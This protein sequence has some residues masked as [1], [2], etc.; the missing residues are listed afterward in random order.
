M[1]NSDL[2]GIPTGFFDLD[3]R[4]D[5]L[6]KGKLVLITGEDEKKKIALARD[7]AK[8]VEKRECISVTYVDKNQ[9]TAVSGIRERI[10]MLKL[11]NR[12]ELIVVENM[13]KLICEKG[14]NGAEN[15]NMIVKALKNLEGTT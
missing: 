3:Y 13:E 6:Q 5:G 2:T 7:I 10:L 11:E 12:P 15:Y 14:E 4:I 1:L 9:D 8:F